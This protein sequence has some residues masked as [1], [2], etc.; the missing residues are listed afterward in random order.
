MQKGSLETSPSDIE[1]AC[2]SKLSA[3]K[4]TKKIYKE[5]KENV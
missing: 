5:K 1:A 3:W 2:F 4:T